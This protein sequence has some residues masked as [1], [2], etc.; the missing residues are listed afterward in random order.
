MGKKSNKEKK[1]WKIDTSSWIL[2]TNITLV[3]LYENRCKK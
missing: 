1:V 3:S 2:I